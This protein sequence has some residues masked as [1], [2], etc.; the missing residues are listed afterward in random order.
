[1]KRAVLFPG[2]GIQYAASLAEWMGASARVRGLLDV[3]ASCSKV[4][5][6]DLM[7]RGGRRLEEP[8]VLQ[9][10]FT[11]LILGIYGEL[12]ERGLE[13]DLVAG[14]SLGEIAA[15]AAAGAVTA[16]DAV[17]LAGVRGQLMSAEARI[18]PGGMVALVEVDVSE[19]E[20]ALSRG[21]LHGVMD[22]AAHNSPGEWVLSGDQAAIDAVLQ[23]HAG[24]RLDVAGPWHASTMNP[25][26][27]AFRSA[28]EDCSFARPRIGLVSNRDGRPMDDPAA[29]PELIAGQLMQPVAWTEVMATMDRMGIAEFVI[30]GPGKVLRSLVRANL[31]SGVSARVVQFPSALDSIEEVG[32]S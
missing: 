19:M 30:P 4:R 9:P 2:Q 27:Q 12:V 16:E 7:S 24:R 17:L 32:R 28:L 11:A 20:D 15:L 26:A 21:R 13:A 1:M 6:T 22:I 10:V 8:A 14:H 23:A 29:I 31:G 25:A 18:S 3:A 5:A